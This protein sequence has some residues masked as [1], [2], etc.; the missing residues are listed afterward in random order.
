M[1]LY[2]IYIFNKPQFYKII[3]SKQISLIISGSSPKVAVST[4][5]T[6]TQINR[7]G[8]KLPLN[9][10][11]SIKSIDLKSPSESNMSNSNH[12]NNS[13]ESNLHSYSVSLNQVENSNNN[14]TSNN[15]KQKL[16]DDVESR[17]NRNFQSN[18]RR[19]IPE[20][21]SYPKAP[22]AFANFANKEGSSLRLRPSIPIT[23][24]QHPTTT[25]AQIAITP[26]RQTHSSSLSS[27]SSSTSSNLST[28]Q[29]TNNQNHN[30]NHH[31][32]GN[33]DSEQLI[34]KSNSQQNNG[35]IS[36]P[37]HT[38]TVT[39]KMT[40]TNGI[41]IN[42]TTTVIKSDL[43]GGDSN[44]KKTQQNANLAQNNKR[45]LFAPYK[46]NIASPKASKLKKNLKLSKKRT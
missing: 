7:F 31:H 46:L 29:T 33:K 5:T 25:S 9:G 39:T 19:N 6:T 36:A 18:N 34:K 24:R 23:I 40:S 21:K 42:S 38:T 10:A 22:T 2:I 27:L 3:F 14:T 43:M 1:L 35:L 12:L 41:K 26:K 28:K 16:D 32:N 4:T 37:H 15:L 8:F 11:N 20:F 44:A 30:N 13:N 17:Q 45:R